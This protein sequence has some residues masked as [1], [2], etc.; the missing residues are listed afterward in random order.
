MG[1]ARGI[2]FQ[3]L[4]PLHNSYVQITDTLPPI[5]FEVLFGKG[6]K[7]HSHIRLGYLQ[8]VRKLFHHSSHPVQLAIEQS[9]IYIHQRLLGTAKNYL[10]LEAYPMEGLIHNSVKHTAL[11]G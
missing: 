6:D 2:L 11:L 5:D 4:P 7:M 1:E 8:Q 3:S 9:G 10:S